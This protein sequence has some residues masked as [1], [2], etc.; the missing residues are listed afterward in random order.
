MKTNLQLHRDIIEELKWEPGVD[1]AQ[2]GVTAEDGVIALT[3]H[4]P[5]YAQKFVVENAAK[6]V[7][8]VKAVANDIEVRPPG[9]SGH[10]DS[11]IATAALHT[12]KW[13]SREPAEN[14]QVTVR[15]GW[16]SLNGTVNW[17]YQKE[18]ADR[19]VR[20]LIGARG[21]TNAI[22]V[23][24][25][26]KAIDVKTGIEA[27]L[28]RHANLDSGQIQVEEGEGTVTLKGD[29]HCCAERE[30]AERVAWAARGVHHVDNQLEITPW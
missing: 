15:D 19:A 30:E 7:H 17:Q 25:E 6:R 29:V 20:N 11:D 27:A 13:D 1:A 5:I 16:I 8:G 14:I 28:R 21:V 18:A 12:L 2:I 4:V 22:V 24:P 10:A 23:K 3:G 9:I 26:H